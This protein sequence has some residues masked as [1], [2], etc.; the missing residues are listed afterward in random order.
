MGIPGTSESQILYRT[1]HQQCTRTNVQPG[2]YP[3]PE[4]QHCRVMGGTMNCQQCGC[5][6]ETHLHIRYEQK[7]VVVEVPNTKVEQALTTNYNGEMRVADLIMRLE[8][9]I[10]ELQVKEK[11]IRT[12]FT[13]FVAFLNQNAIAV[14]ND[15]YGEY[16]EQSIKLAKNEVEVTGQGNAKVEQLEKYLAEYREEVAIIKE[17]I[18][19]A[20]RS[21]T[22]TSVD[23]MK[24]ELQQMN[25]LGHQFK[26]FLQ[27]SVQA[28]KNCRR[29]N[30][31]HLNSSGGGFK[32]SSGNGYK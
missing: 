3:N 7:Q 14:I 20:R 16:L 15:A 19:E 24:R 9:R 18:K 11:R 17:H 21:T 5:S 8:R 4:L 23:A 22:I 28:P 6:W 2:R 25:E 26:T 30:E 29:E 12:A 31:V 13:K 27:V 32:G 1:C 10:E